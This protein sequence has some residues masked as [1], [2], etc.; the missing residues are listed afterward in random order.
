MAER[1]PAWLDRLR[2]AEAARLRDEEA[3][4]WQTIAQRLQYADAP[5]ARRAALRHRGR[6]AASA[7]DE[8]DGAMAMKDGASADGHEGGH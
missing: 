2:A 4:P 3:Q 1:P 7:S 6:V 5:T 8:Q